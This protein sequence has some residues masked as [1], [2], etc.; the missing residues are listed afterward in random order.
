MKDEKWKMNY[1]IHQLMDDEV[2]QELLKEQQS[3]IDTEYDNIHEARER[4][5]DVSDQLN[6]QQKNM[7]ARLKERMM[8]LGISKDQFKTGFFKEFNI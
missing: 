6:V 1:I 2:I 8:Q 7:A 3:L 5:Y 4:V